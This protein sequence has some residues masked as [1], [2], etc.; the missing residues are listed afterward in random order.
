MVAFCQSPWPRSR[1]L[2]ER[3]R[4]A[5]FLGRIDS[6]RRGPGNIVVGLRLRVQSLAA[7]RRRLFLGERSLL[8]KGWGVRV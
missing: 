4:F 7:S 1:P 6:S 5:V 8:P 3:K 2:P